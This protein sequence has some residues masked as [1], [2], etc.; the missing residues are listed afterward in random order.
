MQEH[1]AQF[2]I[3][4]AESARRRRVQER[5]DEPQQ[6]TRAIRER[7]GARDGPQPRLD[8]GDDA[9]LQG[10]TGGSSASQRCTRSR[11]GRWRR[12][13][14]RCRGV[15]GGASSSSSSSLPAMRR[16]LT[17]KRPKREDLRFAVQVCRVRC[18]RDAKGLHGHPGARSGRESR[19]RIEQPKRVAFWWAKCT[20][21]STAAVHEEREVQILLRQY[22]QERKAQC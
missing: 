3:C 6:R 19:Q 1:E 20:N 14:A 10:L 5:A 7:V 22:K 8:R 9:G 13:S 4:A 18:A 21:A 11:I 17:A 16:F 15:S 12:R 2:A